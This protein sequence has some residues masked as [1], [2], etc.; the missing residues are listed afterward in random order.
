MGSIHLH[1]P[2]F[3]NVKD[4]QKGSNSQCISFL[5]WLQRNS[6][7]QA[8]TNVSVLNISLMHCWRSCSRLLRNDGIPN[9]RR[10]CRHLWVCIQCQSS[11][12]YCDN[13]SNCFSSCFCGNNKRLTVWSFASCNNINFIVVSNVEE[14]R[15]GN[16]IR[17]GRNHCVVV[18]IECGSSVDRSSLVLCNVKGSQIP[19]QDLIRGIKIPIN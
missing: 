18:V 19:I 9:Q 7:K 17:S 4:K 11:N 14:S 1:P 3:H 12:L 16:S 6:C 15:R 2:L 13:F 5:L 10:N 8:L